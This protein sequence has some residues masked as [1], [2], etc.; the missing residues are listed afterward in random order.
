M[1]R[2]HAFSEGEY[3]HIYNRGVDKR[4]IFLDN[5][6]YRRFLFLLADANDKVALIERE[7]R[8]PGRKRRQKDHLAAVGAY[9]LMPNHFH[10]LVKEI[11]EGGISKFMQK[12][13]TGYV[14][15]FNTKYARTGTLFGGRFQSR[16]VDSDTYLR[17]LYAY[18]HLNPVKLMDG[19][20]KER[21]ITNFTKAK[22]F[23]DEYGYS[24][25][26]YYSRFH[27][28]KERNPE[29]STD[30]ILSSQEFPGYFIKRGDF[31]DMVDD[32]LRYRTT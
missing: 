9:V 26:Q 24:S 32:W 8:R 30:E 22:R 4:D 5:E 14:M 1:N 12:V 18:I 23:L 31:R 15:Y 20:W 11:E 16:H 13:M 19:K 17:Y 25:Y 3:Y 28:R 21:G 29:L 10:L 2:K 6:D 7:A 27:G